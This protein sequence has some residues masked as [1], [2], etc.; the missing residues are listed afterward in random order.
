M[1]EFR[2]K[3][4]ELFC[5]EL[6][7]KDIAD[8]VGTPFYLYSYKTIID[9][10]QKIKAAFRE[11][12]PL[13]CFS[14]KS[15]SNL[16]ICK[17]L[18][19][20]GSGLDIVSG[21]ELYKA[22][23][24]G[25]DP[26]KIVYASVGKTQKEIETAIKNNILLFNVESIPELELINKVARN[27]NKKVD[28]SLRI[29]PEVEPD[30]HYYIKTAKKESKFGIDFKL[31]ESIFINRKKY[32]SVNIVG[33]H[34]HIGS[35]ITQAKPFVQAINKVVGLIK[36]LEKKSIKLKYLNIGGGLG[37]IYDKEK[38]QTAQEFAKAVLPILKRA[39]LK[40][41]LEPG[42]FIVGNGGILVT[43]VTYVKK[44]K[45]KKFAIVDSG[46]N[47]LIRPSLYEAYHE[48]LPVYEKKGPKF[49]YD[50]VGPICESGDFFGKNRNLVELRSGDYLAI[51]SAGAYGF[52]MSSNYNS[53]PRVLEVMVKENKFF[54]I[55]NR[56]TYQDLVRLEKIPSFL[57]G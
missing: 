48:I 7:I 14:M 32:T 2:Y 5:E 46:M 18:V 19:N 44:T 8:K 51:M 17:A 6:K 47:D 20:E 40:I 10:Y 26:K 41:I 24:V 53:R 57:K 35:Q 30:T 56:E 12:S 25:V 9:H 33:L 31:A 11:V 27:L 4:H 13:I 39:N 50:I 45:A 3:N 34:L 36:K 16:A 23:K 42:R 1:H 29:N 55:R 15:N 43:K 28:V 38:P 54:I 37:I 52:S 49:K 21:G 22:L